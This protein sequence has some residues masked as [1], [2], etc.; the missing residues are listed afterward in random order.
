MTCRRLGPL[1][2]FLLGSLVF[3]VAQS[4]PAAW[5][6]EGSRRVL[7][8]GIELPAVWPSRQAG[9]WRDRPMRIPYLE[10][11]PQVIP[12]DVGRQLLV[13][14]FLIE[15]MTLTRTFHR[16]AF[17]EANPV[18]RPDRPWETGSKSHSAMV[19]SDGVWYDDRDGTMK[20]WY[21]DGKG[22]TCL[23]TSTDGVRW[24]K[25]V[26]DVV[27]G[28]NIVSQAPRDASTVWLDHAAR[29][30]NERFK[31]FRASWQTKIGFTLR[32]HMSSDG[33]H[34]GPETVRSGLSWDRSSVFYNPFRQVWVYS[35]RGHDKTRGKT[36][37]VRLYHEGATLAD[38][39]A[40][41]LSS[42]AIASGQWATGEPV[43][44]VGSD[45]LD[46]HH[47]NPRFRHLAPQLY[48]L[49]VFAY[50]SLMIGLFVI[51]QGPDN[52]TCK[53]LG[54]HKRN[55]VFV[56]YSRDEFHWDRPD[57]K[58][59]LPVGERAERV[60]N[61]QR[62]R[63]DNEVLRHALRQQPAATSAQW[64]AHHRLLS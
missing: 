27:P 24:K 64:R 47:P 39:A 58:P 59:F 8:N 37:R 6:D 57:R 19:Y 22:A 62:L 29:D 17:H 23:A 46:P 11:P 4:Q 50:E 45:K 56:G 32:M 34:W 51:W 43:I 53:K 38:A 63:A 13:D 21:R 1:M 15:N 26:H 12:I 54:I 52:E 42:D 3:R 48:N 33:V 41:N 31:M 5:S 14:D 36:H 60:S 40:W 18:L 61:Q 30:P 9:R 25:P 44:W 55:Q 16:P 49:D 2:I 20:M 35:I 28:T 7:S 10:T